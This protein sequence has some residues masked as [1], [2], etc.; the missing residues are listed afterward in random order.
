M[1]EK[2]GHSLNGQRKDYV[3]MNPWDPTLVI[4]GRDKP[5]ANVGPEHP[6]YDPR[7]KRSPIQ[8]TVD[9]MK[10]HG[11]LDPV[12]VAPEKIDGET[13]YV[14]VDG[15]GRLINAREAWSQQAAAGVPETERVKVLVL[16]PKTVR[17]G[18]AA[19]DLDD[20]QIITNEHRDNDPLSVRAEKIAMYV[21][22]RVK[23]GGMSE[24]KA[25]AD[26]CIAFRLKRQAVNDALRV[27]GAASELKAANTKGEIGDTVLMRL[28]ALPANEQTTAL[29]ELKKGGGDITADDARAFVTTANQKRKVAS[30]GKQKQLG[31]DSGH[32]PPPVRV[33]P[34]RKTIKKLLE[35]VKGKES[36]L[37]P[38]AQAMLRYL[39]GDATSR[40]VE[41]LGE[42]LK[43]I[44]KPQAD[45]AAE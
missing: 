4:A 7:C 15:R 26:A 19:D 2:G 30:G 37:H 29:E 28:S 11:V 14:I 39:T 18:W 20:I 6:R 31:E 23:V 10:K 12:H 16:A 44:E 33:A 45:R 41:G 35:R 1:G 21:G 5:L 32:E 27:N 43:A 13:Y 40:V 38:Q 34:P 36:G 22:R 25:I 8:E 17:G 9:S 24:D 42:E 3:A